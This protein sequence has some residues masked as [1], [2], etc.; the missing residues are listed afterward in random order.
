MMNANKI[1]TCPNKVIAL[2]TELEDSIE[3]N[4]YAHYYNV[5]HSYTVVYQRI[6]RELL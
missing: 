6:R 3:Y 4:Y 5:Y 2:T 1:W